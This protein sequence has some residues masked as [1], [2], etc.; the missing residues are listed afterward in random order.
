MRFRKPLI[1]V[2][3]V[4]ALAASVGIAYAAVPDGTGVI[5]ACYAKNSGSLRV[6]D[7]AECKSGEVAL[8]WNQIGP[9]GAIGE[10]GP[11][12]DPGPA[13]TSDAFI[14][15]GLANA[16]PNGGTGTLLRKSVPAGSYVLSASVAV[17]ANGAGDAIPLVRCDLKSGATWLSN[18]AAATVAN[19]YVISGFTGQASL[20]LTGTFSPTATSTVV[21]ECRQW[22][23]DAVDFEGVLTMTKVDT[24]G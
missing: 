11:P 2:T 22:D 14:D 7:T 13:G 6:S 4:G 19:R 20:S 23:T 16:V 10:Q 21:L 24:V 3:A 18:S 15:H 17:N 9:A 8:S 1:A 5:H 12:G